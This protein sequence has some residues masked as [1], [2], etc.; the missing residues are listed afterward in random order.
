M[1]NSTG[2]GKKHKKLIIAIV[3]ILIL[4]I[5]AG[6]TYWFLAKGKKSAA[7]TLAEAMAILMPGMPISVQQ[8]CSVEL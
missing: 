3:V 2:K 7:N 1:S 5:I 4:A 8:Q 6:G